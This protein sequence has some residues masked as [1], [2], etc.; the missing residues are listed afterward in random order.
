MAVKHPPRCLPQWIRDKGITTQK[1]LV[2]ALLPYLEWRS[3][4]K[5]TEVFLQVLPH[6]E[7]SPRKSSALDRQ[8]LELLKLGVIERTYGETPP[9]PAHSPNATPHQ[10]V[11]YRRITRKMPRAKRAVKVTEADVSQNVITTFRTPR[12]RFKKSNT[13][14]TASDVEFIKMNPY[15]MSTRELGE[16]FRICQST[17]WR[18]SEGKIPKHLKSQF[19]YGVRNL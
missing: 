5:L 11:Y 3:K 15:G 1:Q 7:T 4:Q 6:A 13:H 17:A 18:I 12:R 8:I 14:I 9:A 19:R 2:M 10:Y 16:M